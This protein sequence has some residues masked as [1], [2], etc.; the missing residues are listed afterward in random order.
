MGNNTTH[1]TIPILRT[2][3]LTIGYRS[4]KG[5]LELEKELDIK[6]HNGEVVCLIGPN[7]CGKSTL[8]RTI[9]GL[10]PPLSGE[11]FISDTDVKQIKPHQYARLI[12]LVLTDKIDAGSLKVMDILSIGRYPYTNYFAE[13]KAKDYAIIDK[14]LSSVHLSE[15]KDRFFN[16][17]SDG[18]KQRVL[19]AKALAQD[20]PLIMLDEPT[21]HLDLPN[22]VEIMNILK[23]LAKETN[24]AILLSTHELD[25][26]LQ[27]AD[28]IWLMNRDDQM[29]HGTPEDLVLN[30]MFEQVFKSNAFHFDRLTGAF[31]VDHHTKGEISLIGTGIES[32][33]TQRALEREGYKV[34]HQPVC[35]TKICIIDGTWQ[36]AIKDQTITCDSIGHLLSEL[37]IVNSEDSSIN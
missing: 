31:K 23:R 30:G 9:A 4:K 34:L 35:E 37:R 24:K 21:A 15:Y 36:L 17:L 19:I 28:T 22:R 25:L 27:T 12:S 14:A 1:L 16:E 33:W 13:L 32:T 2:S 3:G 29:K 7:G 18:E 8:M 5:L 11:T 10:Q 26:A 6:I 20:T